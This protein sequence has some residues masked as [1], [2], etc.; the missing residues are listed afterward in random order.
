MA[1]QTI[2][3]QTKITIGLVITVVGLA[4]FAGGEFRQARADHTRI[5]KIEEAVY[6]NTI[7]IA[8]LIEA[9]KRDKGIGED[10]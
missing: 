2:S 1:S 3:N 4:F 7:S 8:Q 5:D 10:Q 9:G 6:A